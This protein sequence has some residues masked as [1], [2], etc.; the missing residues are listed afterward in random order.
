MFYI[1]VDILIIVNVA[2]WFYRW[3]YEKGYDRGGLDST[4]EFIA[5]MQ[6]SEA[7]KG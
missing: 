4:K 6:E 3:G 2:I 1:I 5:E 7:E